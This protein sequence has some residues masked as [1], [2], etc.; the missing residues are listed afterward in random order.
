MKKNKKGS[1]IYAEVQPEIKQNFCMY[2]AAYKVSALKKSNAQ[3][4]IVFVTENK[5]Y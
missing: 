3:D 4:A 2:E 1:L 5:D